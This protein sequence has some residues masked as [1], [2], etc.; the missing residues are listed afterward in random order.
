[1]VKE[2]EDEAQYDDVRKK[3]ES[4]IWDQRDAQLKA[5]HDAR[6]ALMKQV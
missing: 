1:M 4:R 5:Q 2:A 6:E 3:A